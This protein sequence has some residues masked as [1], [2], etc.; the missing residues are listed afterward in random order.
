M[1][2]NRHTSRTEEEPES[3]AERLAATTDESLEEIE[4]ETVDIEA[5]WE[6]ATDD[7]DS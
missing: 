7:V 3:L 5:P 2:E 1:P 4:S 6:A